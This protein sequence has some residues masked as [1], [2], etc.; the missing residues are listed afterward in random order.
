MFYL[1]ASI[2]L[3]FAD[4]ALKD[5][6]SG[7]AVVEGIQDDSMRLGHFLDRAD[8]RYQLPLL[9]RVVNEPYLPAL[10]LCVPECEEVVSVGFHMSP[11]FRGLVP[12]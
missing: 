3:H 5:A 6:A 4:D 9:L 12:L 10:R 1:E 11:S 7:R 8:A 2:N